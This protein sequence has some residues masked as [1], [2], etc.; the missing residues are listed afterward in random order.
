M[1]IINDAISWS[2]TLE[3]SIMLLESS[4]RYQLCSHRTFTVQA[5]IKTIIT[6]D[7]HIFIVHAK[8][9]LWPAQKN[10]MIINGDRKWC[11][12]LEHHSWVINYAPRVIN[13]VSIM[14][15]ENI[16]STGINQND[17]HLWLSYF[18]S[19][20][21][22]QTVAWTIKI[23]WSLMAIV[24]DAIS[25]SITLESSIMLLE[26]SIRYQ[27]FS[28]RTFTVQALIKTIITFDCHIFIVQAKPK[29]WPAL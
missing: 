21:Q 4:I 19:T 28:H 17:N 26:S 18:Y 25:W 13:L 7:C 16:Y 12:K 9:K 2:I 8:P 15:P 27:L 20:G 5:L 10:M 14:L 24:N 22:T 6:Y 11:Y 23:W 29:L 3:S 1:A